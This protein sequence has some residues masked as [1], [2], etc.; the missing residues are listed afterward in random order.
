MHGL[1]SPPVKHEHNL[2]ISLF[3]YPQLSPNQEE[4]IADDPN[5]LSERREEEDGSEDEHQNP[6][7]GIWNKSLS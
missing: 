6:L 7:V 3:R 1:F 5:D 4:E 2:Q